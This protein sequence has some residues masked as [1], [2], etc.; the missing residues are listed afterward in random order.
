MTS[1]KVNPSH[2]ISREF[3]NEGTDLS[4][5]SLGRQVSRRVQRDCRLVPT[6][7]HMHIYEAMAATANGESVQLQLRRPAVKVGDAREV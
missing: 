7:T 1:A 6:G 4:T 3:A 2:R 5:L